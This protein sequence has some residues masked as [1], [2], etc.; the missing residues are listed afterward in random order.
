MYVA[1]DA[2]DFLIAILLKSHVSNSIANAY[3]IKYGDIEGMAYYLRANLDAYEFIII[4][5]MTP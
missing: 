3:Y 1:Y 5:R 2:Y 4:A